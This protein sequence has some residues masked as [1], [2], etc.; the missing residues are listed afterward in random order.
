MSERKMDAEKVREE[1]L[2][3][4]HESAHWAYLLGVVLGSTVLM[5]IYISLLGPTAG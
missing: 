4:V 3:E 2:A 5:L 1:H